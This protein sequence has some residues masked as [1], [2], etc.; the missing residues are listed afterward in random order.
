MKTCFTLSSCSYGSKKGRSGIGLWMI[1]N[2]QFSRD[3]HVPARPA[4]Q[5]RA[6]IMMGMIIAIMIIVA[7]EIIIKKSLMTRLYIRLK[8]RRVRPKNNS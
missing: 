6:I 3:N 2:S 1:A 7:V 8:Y 4:K 5:T